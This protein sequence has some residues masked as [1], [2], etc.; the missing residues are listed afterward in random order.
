MTRSSSWALGALILMSA[1]SSMANDRTGTI[2]YP[3]LGANFLYD[4]SDNDRQTDNGLGFHLTFGMPVFE[5]ENLDIEFGYSAVERDRKIDGS[6]EY[7]RT[8]HADLLYR[9]GRYQLGEGEVGLGNP[10]ILPYGLAGL[11]LVEEDARGDDSYHLGAS[12]A[13]GALFDFDL[14]YGALIRSELR[15]LYQRNN[16]TFP[17]NSS[18]LDFRLMVGLQVPIPGFGAAPTAATPPPPPACDLT[19]VD[20]VTGRA[21]CDADSDGDGVPDSLDQCPGTLP[22]TVVD[23]RGCP[24]SLAPQVIRGVN[25]EFDSAVLTE[26]AKEILKGTATTLKEMNDPSLLIEIGGHTDNLGTESYNL[27]LSQVRA[28]SVRQFLIG[29]GVPSDQLS[30]RGYGTSKPLQGNDTEDGRAENR[31]VEFRILLR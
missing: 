22:G 31:R 29:R 14:P 24:V 8:L 12:L 15:A 11:A 28:E 21:D 13:G 3:Y 9:L 17:G 30:A 2:E 27:K 5:I 4:L 1:G 20:P 25:F 19:V 6:S 7:T 18:L 23:A 10:G 16:D 26:S